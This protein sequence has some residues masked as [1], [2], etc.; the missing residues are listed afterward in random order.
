MVNDLKQL[1]ELQQHYANSSPLNFGGLDLLPLSGSM[2]KD[3]QY[4]NKTR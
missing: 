1:F 4:A 2:L 3:V